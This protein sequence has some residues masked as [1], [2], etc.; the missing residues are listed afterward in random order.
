MPVPEPII[1]LRGKSILRLVY[2]V[3]MPTPDVFG[4]G[5][6]CYNWLFHKD[7][8]Y[9]WRSFPRERRQCYQKGDGNTCWTEKPQ[10]IPVPLVGINTCFTAGFWGKARQNLPPREPRSLESSVICLGPTILHMPAMLFDSPLPFTPYLIFPFWK[11]FPLQE[12]GRHLTNCKCKW[13]T[14]SMLP[15]KNS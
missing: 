3:Y 15:F 8:M 11:H 14:S 6:G 7:H 5:R 9:W 1:V 13:G 10:P 4:R 2:L 12:N